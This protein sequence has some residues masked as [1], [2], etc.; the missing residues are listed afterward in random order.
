VWPPRCA[1]AATARRDEAVAR[2]GTSARTN[3]T[4][5]PQTRV[6]PLTNATSAVDA[7]RMVDPSARFRCTVR[8]PTLHDPFRDA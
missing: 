4:T 6:L 5:I 7:D 2:R 8:I 1:G 3:E